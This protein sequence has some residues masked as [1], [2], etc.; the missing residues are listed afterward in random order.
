MIST[1]PDE[2]GYKV[3][4]T[5]QDAA[6]SVREDAQALRA[7]CLELV[8][9]EDLTADEAADRL[10][11]SVLSIR[12]RFSELVM[13]R[14]IRDSGERRRNASGKAAIVWTTKPDPKLAA[15]PT[16]QPELI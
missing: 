12:P 2:P 1:Y 3:A 9:A 4:G 5:S 6:V 13:R 11:R 15:M 14:L 16:V 7:A 10:H 8:K